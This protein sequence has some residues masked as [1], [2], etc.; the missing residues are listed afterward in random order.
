MPTLRKKTCG[1]TMR[2]LSAFAEMFFY[3]ELVFDDL[4]F[5][6]EGSTEVELADL[7]INLGDFIIAIQL[8]SRSKIDQTDDMIKETKWLKKKCKNAKEQVKETL[9]FISSGNLPSF[10]N[11]RGECI[12]LSSCAK[13]MPLVVFENDKIHAYP[14]LL[15]KHT[16][17]GITVSTFG[18]S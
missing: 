6:P 1:S 12:E 11:K 13:L 10:K 14:H 7:L 8:K 15:K 3:K 4:C 9:N 17:D 18:Q 5:I 2:E 16:E